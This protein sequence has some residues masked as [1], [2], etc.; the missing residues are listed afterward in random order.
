MEKLPDHPGVYFPPPLLYIAMFLGTMAMQHIVNINDSFFG[1]G[2]ALV[3]SFVLVAAGLTLMLPAILLFF[4]TKNS[5]I[6]IK[7]ATSLQATGI[8]ALTRNPMYLGLLLIYIGVAFWIGNW[9]TFIFTPVLILLV[10]KLIIEKEENYLERAFGAAYVD[11]KKKVRR[12][13]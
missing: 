6:P 11:Y 12:W 5:L 10:N 1:S 4:R 8:Y 9:W 7:P 2:I 3:G 13:I